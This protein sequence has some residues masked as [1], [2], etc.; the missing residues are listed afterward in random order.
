MVHPDGLMPSARWITSHVNV[1]CSHILLLIKM[2]SDSIGVTFVEV[3]LK[4]DVL[5]RAK[6]M[7]KD[8]LENSELLAQKF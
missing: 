5:M 2:M 4:G 1:V 7:L 3:P 6:C 8:N